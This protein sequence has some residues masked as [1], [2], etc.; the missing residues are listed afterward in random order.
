VNDTINYGVE[1]GVYYTNTVV[2]PVK[3]VPT[4]LYGYYLTTNSTGGLVT[5]ATSGIFSSSHVPGSSVDPGDDRQTSCGVCHSGA[6]RLAMID[7]YEARLS[8]ITNALILPSAHD[9]GSWGPTCGLCHDPHQ[10][11]QFVSGYG[12][13]Y[14]TNIVSGV[15][16]R[17]TNYVANIQTLQLR[18]PT[19][20]SNFFTMPSQSDKRY[21]NNGNPYYMN[22]TFASMYNPNIN[23]CGQCHNT[24][25]ARWDGLAYGLLT[26]NVVSAFVTNVV[27]Q[28]VYSNSYSYTT[29]Q[30][31]GIYT[32]TNVYDLGRIEVTNVLPNVTNAVVT[33]GLTTNVTGLSRAPHNSVQY[34]ILIGILQP[35]Y[36][37]TT[38]GKTVYTNGVVNNGMGLYATHSGIVARNPVNTNQCATCHVPSYSTA[39]GNVTG[40]TFQLDTY[41]CVICHSSLP[42]WEVTQAST[43]NTIQNLVTLLNQWAID[44]AP[45]ILGSAYNTSLQNSW[46]YTTPGVLASIPNAGPSSANQ[47]LLP[48]AILQARFDTYM[49]RNDGSL[50]VHNPT[51]IPILLSDA[52][53]KVLSQYPIAGFTAK[54]VIGAPQLKVVFSNLGAS[55]TSYNWNFGDGHTSTS[56][57][58]TNTYASTGTYT[59]TFTGTTASGTETLVRSNYINVASLPTAGFTANPTSGPHPLTVNFSNSSASGFGVYYQWTFL[60]T[61]SKVYSYDTNPSFTFTNAGTYNVTLKVSNVAGSI[62]V[63]NA[64]IVN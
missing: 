2:A 6:A 52:E 12:I 56:A 47:L 24:R 20:S 4:T 35:D 50:G 55:L 37:N 26:N 16:N 27:A 7:D 48:A 64:I 53:T 13:R 19:W 49:V 39:N 41:N 14:V 44:K 15:T 57:N 17:I 30:Y 51:F 43:T 29:N 60:T 40:H 21:D 31:G 45:A 42:S 11:N 1:G 34:N 32:L 59:V 54:T 62:T 5:N 38:N 36:L 46:E 61:P 33:V 25:G 28:E 58:P 3:G 8:G 18:N 22:T 9:A 23:V 10:V 63:T